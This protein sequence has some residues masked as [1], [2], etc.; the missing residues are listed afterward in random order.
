MF[1][2]LHTHF[3]GSYS[4][5]LLRIE[6]GVRRIAEFGQPAASITDHG[7]LSFI[8]DFYNA[9]RRHGVKPIL[10]CECYFVADARRSIREKDSRRNHLILLA[11]NNKGLKNLI[12]LNNESWLQ[13]C[14]HGQRGLTDWKLLEKYHGGLICMTACYWGSVSRK[15]VCEGLEEARA[16]YARYYDIFGEDFYPEVGRHGVADEERSNAGLG[17]LAEIFG[18]KVALTN[19]VHYL[20]QED[21]VVHDILIKTRFGFP[22]NFKIDA[23]NFYLKSSEE[24][25]RL[26]FPPAYMEATLEVAEKCNVDLESFDWGG[27][28][29]DDARPL[30]APRLDIIDGRRAIRATAGVLKVDAGELLAALPDGMTIEE[31]LEAE[32]SFA[33]AASRLPLV[34]EFSKILEGLPRRAAPDPE[35][36]VSAAV[37]SAIPV[38]IAHGGLMSQFTRETLAGLGIE[39]ERAGEV[40]ALRAESARLS[41]LERADGLMR[42]KKYAEARAAIRELHDRETENIDY[43]NRI[44]ATYYL[45]GSYTNAVNWY[46]RALELNGSRSV[47]PEICVRLAWCHRRLEDKEGSLKWLRSALDKK[48]G[49]PQ[50][51]YGLGLMHFF[52][53]DYAEAGKYLSDFVKTNPPERTLEKARKLLATIERRA[54]RRST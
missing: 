5:S 44:A 40:P 8:V 43:V 30:W 7:D 20:R 3:L 18:S 16:E 22:S 24:M 23:Q 52:D 10:G 9:C 4:D 1:A 25:K 21:W 2:H 29:G 34:V 17:K 28:P 14:Y 33:D 47:A 37:G 19:D 53:N 46:K 6:E 26:G 32:S 27:V 51:L 54:S 35:W 31:A 36:A 49:Y 15:Y 39:V 48:P 38:K 12:A 45:E 11:K 50:A 13:N 42:Q 41:A